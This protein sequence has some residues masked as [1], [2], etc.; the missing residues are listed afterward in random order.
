ACSS[1]IG[2]EGHS[3]RLHR[4]S[5]PSAVS[6]Q[7]HFHKCQWPL[8]RLL[9]ALRSRYRPGCVHPSVRCTGWCSV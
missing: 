1:R 6:L 3:R 5:N 4:G 2:H 7:R 8:G 9:W